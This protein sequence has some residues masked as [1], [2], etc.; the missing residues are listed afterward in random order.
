VDNNELLP[1]TKLIYVED[2]NPAMDQ[3]LA[4]TVLTPYFGSV[5]SDLCLRSAPPTKDQLQ[6]KSISKVTFVEYINLPGILSDR[7]LAL[8]TPGS[9]DQRINEENFVSLM[10]R[11]F[12]SS[13]DTKMK[14]TF[15]M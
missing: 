10:L 8:A 15:D 14:L 13:L 11:T 1:Q 3:Q 4:K 7:Y 2:L 12:S 6:T 9:V 5:F